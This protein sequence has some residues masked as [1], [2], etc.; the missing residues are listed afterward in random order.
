MIPFVGA[1]MTP[2]SELRAICKEHPDISPVF[3]LYHT[4]RAAIVFV[5]PLVHYVGRVNGASRTLYIYTIIYHFVELNNN[6]FK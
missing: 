1:A 3:S 2:S 6:V 4:S 5:S